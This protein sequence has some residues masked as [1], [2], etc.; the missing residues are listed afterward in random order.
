MRIIITNPAILSLGESLFTFCIKFNRAF[1][2]N[3]L[4]TGLI[5]K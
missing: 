5:G 3:N 4:Q 1:L 2:L